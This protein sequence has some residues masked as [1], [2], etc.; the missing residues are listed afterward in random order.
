[1]RPTTTRDMSGTHAQ[2]QTL[3]ERVRRI[4]VLLDGMGAGDLRMMR[5]ARRGL[6][7]RVPD[8]TLAMARVI[9]GLRRATRGG[10][11]ATTR[12][13]GK[14]VAEIEQWLLQTDALRAALEKETRPPAE[15]A[16]S[17]LDAVETRVCRA[18]AEIGQEERRVDA[19][20]QTLVS[21]TRALNGRMATLAGC[22]DG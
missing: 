15:D 18:D 1:M 9:D 2:L 8:E 6:R 12:M 4:E 14:R 7:A 22:L 11:D 5:D 19:L 3:G 16:R 20:L 21:R 13:D 17:R 10:G